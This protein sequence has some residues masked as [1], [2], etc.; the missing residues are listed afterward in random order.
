MVE[1]TLNS[2]TRNSLNC[3][4][5]IASCPDLL[6]FARIAILALALSIIALIPLLA[7]D[8]DK[9]SEKRGATIKGKIVPNE[10]F[11]IAVS[12]LEIKLLQQVELPQ[13]TLPEN[14]D[15]MAVADREKWWN[16]FQRTEAGKKLQ[17]ER[18][19]LI[20]A[21]QVFDVE[22]EENGG[23]IV[24]DVPEGRYG[25]RGRLD[26]L[27]G[28]TKYAFEV[29]GQVDILKEV[30]EVLL[31]P[32]MIMVT[33]LLKAGDSTPVVKLETFDGVRGIENS[34]LK[35]RYVLLNFWSIDS[36]PS[37]E[38]LPTVQDAVTKLKSQQEITLLSVHVDPKREEALQ[39]V[40]QKKVK[41]W[42]GYAGSWDHEMVTGFGVRGIPSLFLLS[43]DEKILMIPEE[44]RQKLMVDQSNLPA[45]ILDRI[46]GQD[47]PKPDSTTST[48][49]KK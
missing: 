4:V 11:P 17:A 5:K 46:N 25:L 37:I 9:D 3:N 21:A 13:P 7:Q 19:K 34:D 22:I 26:K 30:D 15:K 2:P 1:T 23:F 10:K 36:P 33:P 41:G 18:Q 44:F 16:E 48:P 45:I 43:P 14:L 29:F 49:A 28:Q 24:Y 6:R 47:Q 42:H 27:I 12:E 20:E 35:G 31:D 8:P 39:Y 40:Q 32:I 38:F